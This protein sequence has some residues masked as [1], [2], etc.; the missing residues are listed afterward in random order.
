MPH[1]RRL[2][3]PDRYWLVSNRT[4]HGTF[5]LRPDRTCGQIIRGCLARE[6]ERK[7]VQLVAYAFLSNHFHLVARFPKANRAAF[8]RDFQGELAGRLNRYRDHA[9][10]I[11]PRPYHRQALL[12]VQTLLDNIA[13]TAANPTR[14]GLVADPTHWPGVGSYDCHQ[15]DTPLVGHWLDHNRWHNL[16]RRQDPPPRQE[17]MVEYTHRLHVPEKLPGDSRKERRETMLAHIEQTR[18][19]FAREAGLDGRHRRPPRSEFTQVDWRQRSAIEESWCDTHRVCA[20][21]TAEAVADYLEKRREV[22]EAYDRAAD[23]WKAGG[24]ATF[25]VG[26]YPPGQARCVQKLE[27]RAPPTEQGA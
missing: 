27:A 22:D 5:L 18:K 13:Y 12:D 11:F 1:H 7:D 17:A 26:T 10:T 9:E 25:P 23:A 20:G 14:H 3:E 2:E 16:K 4:H 15:D 6:C 19:R 21:R 8:M 24:E